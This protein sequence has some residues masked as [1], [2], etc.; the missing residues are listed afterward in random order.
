MQLL[1]RR[2]TPTVPLAAVMAIMAIAIGTQALHA[3][4]PPSRLP[5]DFAEPALH[6]GDAPAPVDPAEELASIQTDVSFW[7]ARVERDPRDTTGAVKLAESSI[8]LARATGD[9]TNYLRAEA[10]ADM[11]LKASP[12]YAPA[13][14]LRATVLVALHRFPE[15]RDVASG[16]LGEDPDDAVAL[17][18]LADSALELGD[19]AAARRAID[20]LSVLA[21]GAAADVRR[22][23]LAFIQGDGA[24]AIQAARDAV[25]AAVDEGAVGSGLAFYHTTL[26]D[27]LAA[28]GDGAD[29][30]TA[31][32]AALN[33]RIG[34]PA[35]SAGLGRRAFAA[36]DLDEAIH[37]F[38][39][40]I[41]SVPQPEWLARRGDLFA[42]RA[43]D[44]DARRSADDLA[45]VEAIAG[46]AGDAANVYD[47]A[48]VLYLADHGQD[49]DRAVRMAERELQ[50]RKDVYGYDAYAWAL[51]AAGRTADAR[52]AIDH[53]LSA[54]TRDPRMLYHAGMIALAAGAPAD[55]KALLADALTL[56]PGFDPLGA[57]RAR[58]ALADLP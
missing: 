28:T 33:D 17:G 51:L 3:L 39:R 57:T 18:V 21:G 6:D 43:G 34:W 32:R 49:P 42:L 4:L 31:Y 38:D 12:G 2:R 56:D 54:G 55:A 50:V 46:L 27:L 16:V 22:A 37:D 29:A 36:G 20:H 52:V 14:G 48:L 10:A 11:A 47:R 1:T 7:A 15:A 25:D 19:L 8:A 53:A 24:S 35:A 23:R 44:G 30:V 26:G 9:V 13:V 58:A 41:A 5:A 45:T 40:A